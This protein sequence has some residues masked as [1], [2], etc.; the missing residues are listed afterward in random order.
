MITQILLINMQAG[1]PQP[2]HQPLCLFQ[3]PVLTS[4]PRRNCTQQNTSAKHELVIIF[5]DVLHLS[6]TV[7]ELTRGIDTTV[8]A[9]HGDEQLNTCTGINVSTFLIQQ[10][11]V[12]ITQL[13][14]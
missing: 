9:L 11:K 6:A 4:H 10:F 8:Q 14:S 2:C 3:Q 13:K 12:A 5:N 7:Y 1:M